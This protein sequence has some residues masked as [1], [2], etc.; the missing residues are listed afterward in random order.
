MRFHSI[1][2]YAID[3]FLKSNNDSIIYLG[4]CCSKIYMYSLILLD[5]PF[6]FILQP[7]LSGAVH[8]HDYN[9]GCVS[10]NRQ[11]KMHQICKG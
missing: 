6:R 4:R 3:L 2:W 9:E 10:N 7:N 5:E 11:K 1:L 8:K